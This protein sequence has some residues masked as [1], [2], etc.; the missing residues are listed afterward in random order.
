MKKRT[1]SINNASICVQFHSQSLVITANVFKAPEYKFNLI[2]I[3]SV[4]T[5]QQQRRKNKRNTF[6]HRTNAFCENLFPPNTSNW[7]LFFAPFGLPINCINTTLASTSN[8]KLNRFN[9]KPAIRIYPLTNCDYM[10]WSNKYVANM[11]KI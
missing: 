2:L 5:Q 3:W 9:N 4:Y 10:L 11:N 7:L 8:Q 1:D 6:L